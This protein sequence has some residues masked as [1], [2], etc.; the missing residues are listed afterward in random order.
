MTADNSTEYSLWKA[1]K[2]LKCH[3]TQVP[4]IRKVDGIWARNNSDKA[5]TFAE[6]LES[7]FISNLGSNELPELRSNDYEDMIPLV[8]PKE[9]AEEIRTNLNS[10]KAPGFD[11]I[12]GTILKKIQKK[13]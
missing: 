1:T 9:I 7:R 10:K 12:T 5:E 2:Y 4:P 11:M 8:T 3:V 6:H 13:L